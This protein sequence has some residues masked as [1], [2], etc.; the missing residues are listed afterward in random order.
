MHVAQLLDVLPLAPHVEIVE[1]ALPCV[2]RKGN[3]SQNLLRLAF[4]NAHPLQK[5]QRMGGPHG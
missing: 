1:A 3:L 2:L 4:W 5:A